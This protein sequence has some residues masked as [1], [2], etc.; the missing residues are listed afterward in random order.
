MTVCNGIALSL[1]I[2]SCN[3]PSSR[4][5]QKK[6]DLSLPESERSTCN[7]VPPIYQDDHNDLSLAIYFFSSLPRAFASILSLLKTLACTNH[8]QANQTINPCVHRSDHSSRAW[9]I[10]PSL[11][12][13]GVSV[14]VACWT[15]A[16]NATV[17]DSALLQEGL[18][19]C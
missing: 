4:R 10:V 1:H 13:C 6:R 14:S 2:T 12:R 17:L 9:S 5:Q 18:F 15:E 8:S 19:V 3:R 11:G 16:F 7:D